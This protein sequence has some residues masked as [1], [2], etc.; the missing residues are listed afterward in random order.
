MTFARGSASLEL[1]GRG[2]EQGGSVLVLP[3]LPMARQRRVAGALLDA[4]ND[5]DFMRRLAPPVREALA[6]AWA[7]GED[8]GLGHSLPPLV[9]DAAGDA[10]FAGFEGVLSAIVR[11]TSGKVVNLPPEETVRKR[12]AAARLLQRVF[13]R[14]IDF[15][16]Q[17]MSLQY[18]AMV[19][20]ID[21]LRKDAECSAAV[22]ELQLGWLVDHMEAHLAPYERAVMTTDARDPEA[23]SA[24]FHAAY[25]NLVVQAAAHH[26]VDEWI[27][28]KIKGAYETQ[29]KAHRK[30]RRSARARQRKK[31]AAAVAASAV[32]TRAPADATTPKT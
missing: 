27:A 13:P 12:A 10:A 7:A 1:L 2:A 25:T 15:L 20:I 11:A 18:T 9:V 23:E 28:Q 32:A 14:G 8:L 5:P 16:S 19:K 22:A 29:L 3:R 4:L 31:K 24:K 17:S 26:P 6:E 21:T 30:E